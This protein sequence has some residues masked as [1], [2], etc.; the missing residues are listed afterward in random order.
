MREAKFLEDV[1]HTVRLDLLAGPGLE[2]HGGLQV[3]GL[4]LEYPPVRADRSG[5]LVGGA[6]GV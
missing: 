4:A 3:P 5:L 6:L 2:P 1:V